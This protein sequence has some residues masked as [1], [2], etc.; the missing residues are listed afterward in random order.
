M[1]LLEAGPEAAQAMARDFSFSLAQTFIAGLLLEQAAGSRLPADCTVAARWCQVQQ[2]LLGITLYC[3]CLVVAGALS[4]VGPERLI[5]LGRPA[6]VS[7]SSLCGPRGRL[8][9]RDL[10]V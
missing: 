2:S 8:P 4:G 5:V 1:T 6:W 9:P 7:E 3:C 10:P